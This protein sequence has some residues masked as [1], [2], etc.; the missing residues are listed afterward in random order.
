[1]YRHIAGWKDARVV[2]SDESGRRPLSWNPRTR[3]LQGGQPS[4]ERGRPAE[5]FRFVDPFAG[6]ERPGPKQLRVIAKQLCD[7]VTVELLSWPL[8]QGLRL[9]GNRVGREFMRNQVGPALPRGIRQTWSGLI[10]AMVAVDSSVFAEI[11]EIVEDQIRTALKVFGP[12]IGTILE[13]TATVL[14]RDAMVGATLRSLLLEPERHALLQTNS[15]KGSEA[16]E[17]R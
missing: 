1:M 11:P 2:A 17:T 10:E 5:R 8:R 6:R 15:R 14:E 12:R 4:R 3:L 16:N 9:F 7:P 13:M